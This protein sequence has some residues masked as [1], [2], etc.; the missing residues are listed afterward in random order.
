[1]QARPFGG[2]GGVERPGPE[3]ESAGLSSQSAR[4]YQEGGG[5]GSGRDGPPHGGTIALVPKSVKGMSGVVSGR[6]GGHR[7]GP[8]T[9]SADDRSRRTMR[10]GGWTS[11]PETG[12]MNG[13]HCG[14]S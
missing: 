1:L 14:V 6:L 8:K 11:A 3:P 5:Q 9:R 12:K 2:S 4:P 13:A 10:Y 7:Q